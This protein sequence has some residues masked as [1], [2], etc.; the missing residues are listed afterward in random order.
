MSS[1]P[2]TVSDV[3]REASVSRATVSYVLNGRRDVRVSEATRQ[4]VLDTARRLGYVGSPAARALRSGRGDVVLLL[5]PGW[6][7]SGQLE[8]LLEEVGRLVAEYGLVCLRYEGEHWQGSLYKLLSRISCAC[9]VTFDPLTA[10][11]VQA[12]ESAGVPEVSSRLLDHPGMPH[13]TAIGQDTIVAA[14]VDHLLDQGYTRLAYLATEE[15]RGQAF[16][17]SR[18]EAF[19]EISTMRGV[20]S[21]VSAIVPSNLESISDILQAWLAQSVKPLGVAAWNDLTALGII[22]SAASQQI[23]VPQNLGVVGGDNTPIAALARPPISSVKFNL[24]SEAK[25]I[26][27]R[28]AEVI[29]RDEKGRTAEP[30]PVVEVVPRLSSALRSSA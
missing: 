5:I 23:P 14:Q 11:D 28:I 20:K 13:N 22:S 27:S 30:V 25:Q 12:L 9:V 3:A 10:D 18:I 7:V 2:L 4:R 19:H 8:L 26:A 15:R 29:G 21:A 17:T 6:E 1:T 16:I 24:P